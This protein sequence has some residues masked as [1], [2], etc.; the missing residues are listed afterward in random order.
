MET[1]THGT[2][3]FPNEVDRSNSTLSG[4]SWQKPLSNLKDRLFTVVARSAD[5]TKASTQF[6]LDFETARRVRVIAVP[7]HTLSRS[8]RVRIRAYRDQS[9]TTLEHDTGWVFAWPSVF[10]LD[11]LE[12]EDDNFWN[13]TYTEEQ[14]RFLNVPFIHFFDQSV[15]AEHWLFEFDDENNP[16][17]YVDISRLIMSPAWQASTNYSWGATLDWEDNDI[18]QESLGGVLYHDER[19]P[20]RV[21]TLQWELLDWD[22]AHQNPFEIKRQVRG[23]GEVFVIFN[24]QEILHRPRR[25]FLARVRGGDPLTYR[26]YRLTD[27]GLELEEIVG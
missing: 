19:R 25:S 4:G 9:L 1:L 16:D 24:P 11:E 12:W 17:G 23:S 6:Q 21:A 18:T 3:A 5:A 20:K 8:A 26:F 7:K 14:V 27:I 15:F 2:L 13:M 10:E 22:E